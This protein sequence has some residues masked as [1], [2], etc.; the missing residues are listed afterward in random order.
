MGVSLRAGAV[1]RAAAV[2]H[3]RVAAKRRVRDEPDRHAR[4]MLCGLDEVAPGLRPVATREVNYREI[5]KEERQAEWANVRA[6]TNV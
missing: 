5:D 2:V 4:T 1:P 6:S 3:R